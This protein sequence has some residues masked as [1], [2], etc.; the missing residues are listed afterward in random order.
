MK[1]Q[2][3]FIQGGGENGYVADQKMVDSLKTALGNEY[4][5]I[6]P[7]LKSDESLP[8]FGWPGEIGKAL[9]GI[10][11]ELILVGHSLGASMILKYFS[12]T[13]AHPKIIQI[14]LLAT[15]FW[16]GTEDWV[17]GLMLKDNFA[18]NM[19]ASIPISMYHSMDDEV[20]P[21]EQLSYYS[22]KLQGANIRR[23]K[24]GGHLF[25]NDL[26]F[27]ADDIKNLS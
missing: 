25:N 3:L 22:Q 17:K 1:N 21:F 4:E 16:S 20:V 19:P 14:F 12:E 15:P 18:D 2:V 11:G 27:L 23:I 6:Y 13:K 9:K 8:D 24:K 10:K 5:I 7:E 26:K